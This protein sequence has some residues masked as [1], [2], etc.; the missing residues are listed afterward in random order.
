MEAEKAAGSLRFWSFF[1]FGL[2]DEP[3][4]EESESEVGFEVEDG[5]GEWVVE[6]A[7]CAG[8]GSGAGELLEEAEGEEAREMGAKSWAVS[9]EG[10]GE[11]EGLL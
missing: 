5:E 7:S 8:L 1:R 10:E 2:L 9:G 3:A 6:E 4:A 11:A